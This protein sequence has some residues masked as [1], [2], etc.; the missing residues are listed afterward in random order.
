[1]IRNLSLIFFIASLAVSVAGCTNFSSIQVRYDE[2]LVNEKRITRSDIST[3]KQIEQLTAS[4]NSLDMNEVFQKQQGL[5]LTE[6]GLS[7]AI[8]HT[9]T[10]Y[11]KDLQYLQLME[12]SF[13]ELKKRGTPKPSQI[14]DLFD[15]YIKQRNFTLAQALQ[16]EFPELKLEKIPELKVISNHPPSIWNTHHEKKLME[17]SS[18]ELNK[19]WHLVVVSHPF[20]HF[21]RNAMLELSTDAALMARLKGKSLWLTP[22][23]RLNFDAM[24]KWNV[25]HTQTPIALVHHQSEWPVID[26]WATPTFYVIKDGKAIHKFSGWPKEGNK[27]KL[28]E[29]L[30]VA[31]QR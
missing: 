21:S 12:A 29:A 26:H 14:K 20:C 19:D 5:D 24:Q 31:E 6:L 11:T 23:D 27:E 25:E 28:L 2:F 17:Q 7:F 13:V 8:A 15:S 3:V 9:M 1:M 16:A 30:A 4:F 22:Q 18:V 10:F